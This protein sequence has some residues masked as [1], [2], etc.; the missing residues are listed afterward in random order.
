[1]HGTKMRDVDT[2]FNKFLRMA[3]DVPNRVFYTAPVR[4]ITSQRLNLPWHL[5]GGAMP[6]ENR[7]MDLADLEKT[8]ARRRRRS[9]RRRVHARTFHREP[10]AVK[11]TTQFFATHLAT[12][13]QMGPQMRAIRPRRRTPFQTSVRKTTISRSMN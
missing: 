2:I 9:T 5:S 12:M 6:H 11:R 10:E 4:F 7:T 3:V 1:M 8:Q 13:P